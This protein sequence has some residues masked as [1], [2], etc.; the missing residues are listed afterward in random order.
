MG[1]WRLCLASGLS[2]ELA[3]PATPGSRQ[4]I[5]RLVRVSERLGVPTVATGD[6]RHASRDDYR[7]LDLLTC[8]RL[9]IDVFTAH[10]ERPRNAERYLVSPEVIRRRIRWPE[11]LRRAEEIAEACHVNLLPGL[12][13]PPSAELPAG[14]SARVHL[15]LLCESG[16]RHR[17]GADIPNRAR[18]QLAR[19]LEVICDLELEEFFL[20]VHEVVEEA[21]R[22]RIR[23]AGR[24]SAANSLVAYLLGITHV[25]PLRHRLL[26]ERFLHGG[27]QGTPDI[28]VDFDTERR[29]EIIEWMEQRFG[30]DHTA[31]AATLITYRLRSALRDSAK[32]LGWSMEDVNRVSKAVMP[33][34]AHHAPEV[35]ASVAN[36]LGD[37]PLIDTLLD[38]AASLAGCPRH[39]GLHAGGMVLSRAPLDTFTPV[40]TSANGVTMVQ[41]A[42]DDIER[43]G[44]VKLDVLGLRMLAV[45]SE[46]VELVARH[47]RR[48]VDLQRLPLDDIQTFNLIRA[49][50]T[51][52]CFQIE[53]QGQLHLLGQHQPE[54][55]QDLIAEVSLFRP[56][57]LQGNMVNPYVRRRRGLEPVTFEHPL[58]E[59]VLADT[60]GVILFQE[61]IL[62]VAHTVAGMSLEESDHFRRLMSKFRSPTEMESMRERFVEGAKG[63]GVPEPVGHSIFDK[64]SKFVGYGFCRSHAAAFAQTVY[65]SCWLKAHYPAAYMAAVM[66]HRPG[67]YSLTTLQQDARTPRRTWG[68]RA[69]RPAGEPVRHRADPR[70]APRAG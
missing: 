29:G 58:L 43:L 52:G 3:H 31:M 53:S 55:F 11:A 22:R 42:K 9:G 2:I 57:P 24:G 32:A 46:S 12:I 23:C 68:W 7:R 15:R 21:R 33:Q 5:E 45:L 35:R 8:I 50:R 13:T 20:V 60:Y 61:Q 40:Q 56:G 65:A 37:S 1:P 63:R 36:V 14:V 18:T 67:M 6:V 27:R 62:E 49:G 47:H 10:A 39:L 69:R 19:E 66:Q 59:S 17:Y 38:S 4:R 51:L 34:S 44:V 41:F 54:T 70:T 26:F 25:D 28:D 30:R 16:L 64:V 48:V